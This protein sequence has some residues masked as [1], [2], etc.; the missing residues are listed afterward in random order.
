MQL[1]IKLNFNSVPLRVFHRS[2]LIIYLE[3][4]VKEVKIE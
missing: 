4:Q 1:I 2:T 3:L